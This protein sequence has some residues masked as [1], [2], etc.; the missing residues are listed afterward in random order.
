[1]T[2]MGDISR[3]WQL[4]TINAAGKRTI[5]V[6]SEAKTFIAQEFTSENEYV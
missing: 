5:K 1:M 2:I 6:I 4:V 3:Y